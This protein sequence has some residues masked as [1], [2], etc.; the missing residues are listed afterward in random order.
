MQRNQKDFWNYCCCTWRQHQDRQ[1]C[2]QGHERIFDTVLEINKTN[3][4]IIQNNT[5]PIGVLSAPNTLDKQADKDKWQQPQISTERTDMA[6]PIICFFLFLI[7]KQQFFVS[8][9]PGPA[10]THHRTSLSR[11]FPCPFSI[12]AASLSA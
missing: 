12:C 6:K 11:V 9:L 3:P 2:Q 1:H 7:T 8:V 10:V 4:Q 5:T